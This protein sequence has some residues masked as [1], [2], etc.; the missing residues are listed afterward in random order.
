MIEIA[1]M[2]IRKLITCPESAHLEEIEYEQHPLGLLIIGCSQFSPSCAVTCARECAARL[3]RRRRI[4]DEFDEMPTLEDALGSVAALVVVAGDDIPLLD[5]TV[6][7]VD[8]VVEQPADEN[9][10]DEPENQ[11]GFEWQVVADD[12]R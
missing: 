3:D 10:G 6:F 8:G 2:A 1:F 7:D 11:I 5:D 9:A 4:T 12:V